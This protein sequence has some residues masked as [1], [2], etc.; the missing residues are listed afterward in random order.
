MSTSDTPQI[1][2]E[3]MGAVLRLTLSSPRTKNAITKGMFEALNDAMDAAVAD[4]EIRVVWLRGAEGAFTSGNVMTEFGETV[5]GDNPVGSH[6]LSK[7]EA[8]PKPIVAQV[9][10]PAIAIGTTVLLHCDLVYASKDAKFMLP[11]V[12]LGLIP[13][14]GSTYLLPRLMGH[15]KAAELLYLGGMFGADDALSVGL[16]NQVL[17]ADELEPT[18]EKVVTALARQAP[19]ALAQTKAFLRRPL[20]GTVADRMVE[21]MSDFQTRFTGDEFAEAI[22]AMKEKR[23]PVFK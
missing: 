14:A 19:Q 18:V 21:E 22:T 9:E 11:F 3:Q 23:K 2:S 6:F 17:D 8:F 5:A 15:A 7:L 13:E 16:V 12:S 20:H 1:I 4:P 10:G